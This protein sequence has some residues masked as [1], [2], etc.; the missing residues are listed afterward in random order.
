VNQQE[1]EEIDAEAAE[2][3]ENCDANPFDEARK[4][5]VRAA[6]VRIREI[7]ASMEPTE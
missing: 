1:I 3:I 7:I 2:G 6:L 4:A 5:K